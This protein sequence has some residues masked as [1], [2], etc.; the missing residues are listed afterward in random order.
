MRL[1]SVNIK[2]AHR[3]TLT[4]TSLFAEKHNILS[5]CGWL[6]NSLSH[7]YFCIAL[8][9]KEWKY[10][11]KTPYQQSTCISVTPEIIVITTGQHGNSMLLPFTFLKTSLSSP[12][13]NYNKFTGNG[14]YVCVCVCV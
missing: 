4:V 10:T 13:P 6:V 1:N 11:I 5:R 2:T 9:K 8:L 7:F 3:K 14:N 12:L